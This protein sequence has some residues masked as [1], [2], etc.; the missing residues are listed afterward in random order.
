MTCNLLLTN[1]SQE[2]RR[3]YLQLNNGTSVSVLIDDQSDEY[4]SSGGSFGLLST[5]NG[6][7]LVNTLVPGIPLKASVKF[8]SIPDT[9]SGIRL[10]RID[11]YSGQS[12]IK[13]DFR[14]LPLTR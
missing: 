12:D 1:V 13:V 5:E 11:A 14:D 9:V 8:G 2:D 7:F 6:G 3:F 10:L 4:R